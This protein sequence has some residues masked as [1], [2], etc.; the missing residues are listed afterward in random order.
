VLCLV[1]YLMRGK[2]KKVERKNG[3]NDVGRKRKNKKKRKIMASAVV[4]HVRLQQ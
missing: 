3:R 1:A 4:D 2:T